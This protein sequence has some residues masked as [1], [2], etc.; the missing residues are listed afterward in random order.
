MQTLGQR[1]Y[2]LRKKKN[3][4]RDAL[5]EKIGVSK[6]AI[7]NWEDN[8]NL[9]KLEYLQLLAS[10]FGC[11]IEY[12]TKGDETENF[13]LDHDIFFAP[14]LDDFE[15]SVSQDLKQTSINNYLPIVITDYDDEVF[16]ISLTNSSMKPKFQSNDLILISPSQ[17][18]EPGDYVL[19]LN[20]SKDVVIRKWRPCGYDEATGKDYFQLIALNPDYPTIDS[21]FTDF[22]V[23]GVAIEHRSKL[24]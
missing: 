19:A 20:S 22:E 1:L 9:P 18:P 23:L 16:W 2:R 7:K 4:A 10:F 15:I 5:G 6:T 21:R 14:V 12:L 8:E 17:K 11:S 13:L 3:L 24:K